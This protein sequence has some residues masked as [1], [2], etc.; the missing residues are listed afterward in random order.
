MFVYIDK[1]KDTNVEWL[2]KTLKDLYVKTTAIASLFD[3]ELYMETKISI[4]KKL[5]VSVN[6]R[7]FHKDYVVADSVQ[8][9]WNRVTQTSDAYINEIKAGILDSLLDKTE[10][11]GDCLCC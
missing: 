1:S 11:K 10:I 5:N 6:V 3:Y 2:E 4:S 9:V 7:Y 8:F